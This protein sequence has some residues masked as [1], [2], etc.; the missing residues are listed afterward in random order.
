[1]RNP[2][3]NEEP[4]KWI[5]ASIDILTFIDS[6]L[7][8]HY[9]PEGYGRGPSEETRTHIMI[10]TYLWSCGSM[11]SSKSRQPTCTMME[12][13]WLSG[14]LAPNLIH[15]PTD[16]IV[17]VIVTIITHIFTTIWPSYCLKPSMRGAPAEH[18]A[19]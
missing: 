3:E 14:T 9:S 8:G 2:R 5:I 6:S 4:P 12:L 7:A 15:L 11:C 18:V 16:I 10:L 13:V 17:P 1:M 19:P